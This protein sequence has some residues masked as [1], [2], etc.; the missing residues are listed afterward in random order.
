M[1][2]IVIVNVKDLVELTKPM[3]LKAFDDNVVPVDYLDNWYQW[4]FTKLLKDTLCLPGLIDYCAPNNTFNN[5]YGTVER[6]LSHYVKSSIHPTQWTALNECE[7]VK[8]VFIGTDLYIFNCTR[9]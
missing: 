4:A 9:V 8:T 3:V 2:I 7:L 5:V 6:Q 1:K